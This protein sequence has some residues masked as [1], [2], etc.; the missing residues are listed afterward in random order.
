MTDP[1]SNPG[2]DARPLVLHL[3]HRFDTGGLENGLVNLINHMPAQA[4][5]HM[6]VALTE[7]TDFKLR[8]QRQ[9]V[10]FAALH[11]PPGQG[12]WLYP[13]F[14]R[15]LAQQRP[16]V[17]HTRNLGTLEFQ[18]PAAIA[19]VPAR[20]HGEHGRDI[21]D[22]D[23]SSRRHRWSRRAYQKFVHR[24]VALSD[25]LKRYLQD[26]IDLPTARITQIYN[27]VD[28]QRFCP[29]SVT[30]PAT[31]PGCPFKEAGL[32]L[33]GTVG[34]MQPVKAQTLLAQAFVLALQQQ[35]QLR[36][37][38]RLVMVGDGPLLA[39]VQAILQSAGLADLAWLA[40]ERSDI[41]DVM[42]MLD[43]FVLPSLAE[44][45]SNTVLEAMASGLPVIATHVGANAELVQHGRTGLIVPSHDAGAMAAALLQM[46]QDPQAA[47]VMGQLG[48]DAA[49]SR[50]SMQAMAASYQRVYDELLTPS[51]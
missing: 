3:V 49:V 33:V 25:D 41:P 2:A 38:L 17:L 13:K 22:L 47:R 21:D 40:G 45:V 15:L 4:Y 1:R 30:A 46:Q 14:M 20:V 7:V 26:A 42:R 16:A 31:V 9:D 6:V 36:S 32:W 43:C 39:D 8:I 50:F 18:L 28:S 37:R 12:L 48:R 29:A 11:K 24:F 10:Q 27:G 35:P 44:G 23:G 19:R 51:R 34:R 5:R